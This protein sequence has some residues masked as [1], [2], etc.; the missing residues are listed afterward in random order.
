MNKLTD[1]QKSAILYLTE[2]KS[3]QQTA[4]LLNITPLEILS[5]L[6]CPE[7]AMVLYHLYKIA[8]IAGRNKLINQLEASTDTIAALMNE[9][10]PPGIRL[11]AAKSVMND[12][13]RIDR[14][15]RAIDP[16]KVANSQA[17]SARSDETKRLLAQVESDWQ[18]I[19][20]ELDQMMITK[21]ESLSAAQSHA[22]VP[23]GKPTHPSNQPRQAA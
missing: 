14:M 1:Q 20:Q 4:A 11:R 8:L 3:V 7:V 18:A 2:G 22:R 9:R 10:H 17:S 12:I 6:E 5:W 13:E 23:R 21:A 19:R 16:A 15:I